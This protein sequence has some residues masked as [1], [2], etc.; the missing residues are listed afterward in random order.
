MEAVGRVGEGREH[1]AEIERKGYGVRE[2]ADFVGL[3]FHIFRCPRRVQVD[4]GVVD[5]LGGRAARYG[6]SGGLAGRKSKG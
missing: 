4:G 5:A 2:R 6:E 3:F 1:M